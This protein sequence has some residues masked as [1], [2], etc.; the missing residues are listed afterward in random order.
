MMPLQDIFSALNAASIQYVV[1]GGIAVNL[2][3]VERLTAD[4]D[5]II[6]LE[7][8]NILKVD[9]VIRQ[10]GLRLKVPVTAEQFADPAMRQEWIEQKNMIVMSYVNPNNPLEM[11]D[12]FV[13]H[14]LPYEQLERNCVH[15]EAFGTTIPIVGL[16]DL[17]TLK[18]RAARPK[19]MY[20]LGFLEALRQKND[21]G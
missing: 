15:K 9:V 21:D 19:D 12:I 7:R 6:H 10:L 13:E 18:E 3:G 1:A 17:I 8:D 11:I 14:P 16:D 20:D 5:L 4:V 2:H